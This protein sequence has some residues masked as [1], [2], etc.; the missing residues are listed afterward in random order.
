MFGQPLAQAYAGTFAISAPVI[1][2][3]VTDTNGA[4]VAGVLIQATGLA[5][6]TTDTNGNYSL[7]V[8]YNWTGTVTP[9]FGSYFFS[10][11]STSYANVVAS[12][13]NQNY[14]AFQSVAPA[15]TA[16]QS[17]GRWTLNWNGISGVTYQVLWST[18]LVTWQPLGSSIPGNSG[19]ME[20][21]MPAG[22]N[23]QEFFQIQA[24][25]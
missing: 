24:G 1:S 12:S 19:P 10:P 22:S 8:P 4:G 25:Y 9:S 14:S 21:S 16:S 13:T 6:A 20:Y 7:T 18:N 11:P 17:A 23:S 3:T 5:S 15:L 2:G